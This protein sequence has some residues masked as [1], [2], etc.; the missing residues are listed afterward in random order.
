MA[1]YAWYEALQLWLFIFIKCENVNH[2]HL[3]TPFPQVLDE[4]STFLETSATA[5]FLS[6][7]IR[8]TISGWLKR[9]DYDAVIKQ[10]W[11][12]LQKTLQTDGTISGIC[13]G[14]GIFILLFLTGY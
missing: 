8:G 1:L 9:S 13:M 12:G 7:L 14:T 10:A 5:M 2:E 11:A 6:S 3:L 4:P